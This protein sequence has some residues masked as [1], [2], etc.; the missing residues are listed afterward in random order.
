MRD[1]MKEKKTKGVVND[2]LRSGDFTL[3]YHDNQ[4]CTLHRGRRKYDIDMATVSNQVAEFYG[5]SDGCIPDEVVMLVRALG[6]KV[7]SI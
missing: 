7:V 5:Q 3:A 1:D 6:G 2:I 4:H